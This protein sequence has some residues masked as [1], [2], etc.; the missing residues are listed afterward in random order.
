MKLVKFDKN[1]TVV[2]VVKKPLSLPATLVECFKFIAEEGV[3]DVELRYGDYLICL[4]KNS[5]KQ[6]II[7]DYDYYLEQKSKGQ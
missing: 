3:K 4:D 5:N 7:N 6:R 2:F 1:T